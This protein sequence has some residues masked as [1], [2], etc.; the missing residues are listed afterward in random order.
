MQSGKALRLGA[1][2]KPDATMSFRGATELS[3]GA[4]AAGV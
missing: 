2:F 1:G 3:L 4:A